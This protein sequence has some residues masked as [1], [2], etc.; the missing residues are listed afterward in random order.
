[1]YIAFCGVYIAFGSRLTGG[2]VYCDTGAE[3]VR[4]RYLICGIDH[5]G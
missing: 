2:K 1:M 3:I 5:V 4:L